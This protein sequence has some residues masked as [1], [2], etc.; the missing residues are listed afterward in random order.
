MRLIFVNHCH[1]ES[2]HV[3]G[4]R[5]REFAA[6]LARNGHQIVLLTQS[7]QRE[8][9]GPEASNLAR[10]LEAH[11]WSTPFHL[12]CRPRPAPILQAM[13]TGRLPK[14]VSKVVAAWQYLAHG[15]VFTDWRAGSRPYWDVLA[16]SFQPDLIWGLFGNTDAWAIAQGLARR[17][18]RPWVRDF[19]DQWTAFVPPSVRALLAARFSDAAAST[20]LS[21][22]NA[23]DAAPW[24]PGQAA[25]IYS[26]VSAALLAIP[27]TPSDISNPFT[28]AL[29]G[30]AYD[31]ALLAVAVDGLRRFAESRAAS[32]VR[33]VYAGTDGDTVA[34]IVG[35]SSA[36]FI[37]EQRGQL[38]FL[39]YWRLLRAADANLYIRLSRPGCWHHKIIELLAAQRPILCCPGE[40]D[41]AR[42][43]VSLVGGTFHEGATA[44]AVA[45]A[46]ALVAKARRAAPSASAPEKL[47]SLTWEAQAEA[48]LRAFASA[49]SR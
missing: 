21:Q 15:G 39:E 28:V 42:R 9:K 25:V 27:S 10:L 19:K 31:A 32:P 41:E 20:S 2:L 47:I 49:R 34:R 16:T 24:F 4:T 14:P 38:P 33:L 45:D 43:L 23:D 48:L 46:L 18:G 11:D 30:A 40:I 6:V 3:C 35:P 26:G 13:R 1:P 5:G 37:F 44:A 29:V 12:A 17:A 22:A 36:R 8:D 7:L